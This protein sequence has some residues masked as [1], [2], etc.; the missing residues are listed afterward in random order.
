MRGVPGRLLS[1]GSV[2]PSP[3][4]QCED[5][6]MSRQSP[7]RPG[8]RDRRAASLAEVV[9]VVTIMGIVLAIA[10]PRLVAALERD[11]VRR[12]ASKLAMDLR[13]AQ[14]EATRQQKG[15]AVKF[16]TQ[17]DSY[18]LVG[19]APG[20]DGSTGYKVHLG[21]DDD[22]RTCIDTVTFG[23][24]LDVTF[25]RYGTPDNGGT[26]VLGIQQTRI[27]VTVDAGTGRTTVGDLGH[28]PED[29][30]PPTK[31]LPPLIQYGGK[32]GGGDIVIPDPPEGGGEIDPPKI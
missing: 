23:N 30:P 3:A 19:L 13:L 9:I 6:V 17:Y 27:T 5:T 1:L 21:A 28:V 26:V 14:S 12:S 22:Y 8:R 4:P 20:A 24:R 16:S 31:T 25:D 11:R 32:I 18:R 10:Q 7:S 2:M 15:V 29:L